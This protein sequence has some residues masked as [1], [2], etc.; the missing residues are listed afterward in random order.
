MPL[1]EGRME[2]RSMAQHREGDGREREGKRKEKRLERKGE[3]G[4]VAV[5]WVWGE[6]ELP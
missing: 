5:G 6:E 3:S 2:Y 4:V 1:F